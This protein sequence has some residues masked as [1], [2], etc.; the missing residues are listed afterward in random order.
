[1]AVRE[2]PG[3]DRRELQRSERRTYRGALPRVQLAVG[4]DVA[5]PQTTSEREWDVDLC[6]RRSGREGPLGRH[7]KARSDPLRYA[8]NQRRRRAPSHAVGGISRAK[9]EAPSTYPFYRRGRLQAMDE[10]ESK[11]EL[12]TLL[13]AA[14]WHEALSRVHLL[15]E[16]AQGP[17]SACTCNGGAQGEGLVSIPHEP[18]CAMHAPWPPQ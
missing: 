14:N 1:M 18:H 3:D 16:Q 12:F 4:A 17:D 5:S 9:M 8:A 2:L 10:R 13:K 7:L 6:E 11:S 15:I